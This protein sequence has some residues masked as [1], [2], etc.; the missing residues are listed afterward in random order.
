MQGH[1]DVVVAV[2]REGVT[3]DRL[4]GEFSTLRKLGE[5]GLPVVEVIGQ[6]EVNG[7]P[8]IIMKR[9]AQ[10]SKDV[11]RTINGRVKL[12]GESRFLNSRSIQDLR[13]VKMVLEQTPLWINDLQFLIGEDG[14]VVV[15]DAIGFEIQQP[16][17]ANLSTIDRLIQAVENNQAEKK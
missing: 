4:D 7:R 15:A 13:R 2:A 3:A 11:A 12:V 10:G 1:A 6:T 9:Y 8:A 5:M 17:K 14:R 16:S